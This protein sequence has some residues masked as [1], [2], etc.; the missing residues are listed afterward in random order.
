MKVKFMWLASF[1]LAFQFVLNAQ[2]AS[3][4]LKKMQ[5]KFDSVEDFTA[6]YSGSFLSSKGK[7]FVRFNGK[8]LYKK[9]KKIRIITKRRI[10][11][12]DGISLW[13][14]DKK[15][16]RVVIS[17]PKDNPNPISIETYLY[18]YAKLCDIDKLNKTQN[19]MLGIRLVPHS[20]KIKFKYAD[21]W[22]S[23]NYF[24]AQIELVNKNSKYSVKLTNVKLNQKLKNSDFHFE[25]KKGV[26]VVDLR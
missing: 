7:V 5:N 13:T 24:A 21:I 11:V 14:F 15:L 8:I 6:D 26:K 18:D 4:L 22:F 16:K 25:I 9:S 3:G 1:L 19:G 20:K 10:I 12:S 23:K 2:T 17:D